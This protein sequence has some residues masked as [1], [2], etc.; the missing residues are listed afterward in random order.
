MVVMLLQISFVSLWTQ[1]LLIYMCR[2]Q[3]L[4]LRLHC[5]VRI[6]TQQ[7]P[8]QPCSGMVVMLLQISSVSL[9]TPQLLINM[10][11][12]QVSLSCLKCGLRLSTQ[13]PPIQT[14]FYIIA[15]LLLI[16][17]V[18]LDIAAADEYGLWLGFVVMFEVWCAAS[19]AAAV[20]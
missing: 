6:L 2:S 4:L 19:N 1:Q 10:V 9:W 20:H 18:A 3:V 7:P 8:T 14:D 11:C 16:F 5:G 17:F 15:M 13:Q 12:C